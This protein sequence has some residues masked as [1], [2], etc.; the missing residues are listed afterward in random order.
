MSMVWQISYTVTSRRKES[1]TESVSKIMVQISSSIYYIIC[2]TGTHA[3]PD[4]SILILGCALHDSG[5][6]KSTAGQE[7]LEFLGQHVD[8]TLYSHIPII[9]NGLSVIP[10]GNVFTTK[11]TYWPD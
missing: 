6:G 8:N 3:L 2:N 10:I 7:M 11:Q 1:A 9:I 5:A 4:M